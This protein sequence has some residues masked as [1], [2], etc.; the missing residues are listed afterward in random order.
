MKGLIKKFNTKTVI[1]REGDQS[2]ELYFILSG[3]VLI[4]TIR[5]TQVKAIDRIGKG[6]F[7]GELSFFDD[8]PRAVHVVTLEPC[9]IVIFKKNELYPY[10]P[11]WYQEIHRNLTKK[12]R[13]LDKIIHDHSIRKNSFDS[14]KPLTIEEQ[15]EIFTLISE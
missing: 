13:L 2:N 1:F 8:K 3:K 12:I 5:G 10:L 14:Q 15:R 7:I 9:E 11:T 6:E 4:C